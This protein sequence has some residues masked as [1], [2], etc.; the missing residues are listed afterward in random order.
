MPEDIEVPENLQEWGI[1]NALE[2]QHRI[3]WGNFMKGR[4]STKFG[5]IQMEAYKTSDDDNHVPAH[6]SAT[7]WTAGLIKELIYLSL[8]VWQQRNR[9]MHDTET[10]TQDIQD[11]TNAL[12]EAEE[13]YDKKHMFPLE[14]QV[15]F[16]RSYLERCS[17]TTK[18]VRLWLQKISDLYDY[19]TQ[20]TLQEFFL[21]A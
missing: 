11:R 8:N 10:M 12:Q 2:E 13:W 6:F 15:H 17:D 4:I 18:Q 1:T 3:G 9:F 14:D 21:Q 16:H 20:R 19:N 7:W 5:Q